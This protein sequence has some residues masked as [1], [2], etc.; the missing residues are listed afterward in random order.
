MIEDELRAAFA[1]HEALTPPAGPVRAAIDRVVAVRRRRRQRVRAAGVALALVGALGVGIPQLRPD[2]VVDDATHFGDRATPAPSGALNVLVLG[3]DLR[4]GDAPPLADSVLLVHVPADRS[5]PY[6]ISLP[7]DLEVDIPGHQRDKLNA[8]F[9]FGAGPGRPD[10]SRGYELTRRAVADLTGVRVDAGLVLTYPAL[11]KV[12]DSLG[13]VEVC[14]PQ[15]VTSA[16]TRRVYPAGCQRLDGTASVDLLRQRRGLPD[17]GLD[18][19]RNAQRFVAGLVRR[20]KEQ[21][22]VTDPVRLSRILSAVGPDL[23]VAGGSVPDL[24]RVIPQL[25]S[26]EPV[27]LSLPVVPPEGAKWQIRA[28]PGAAPAFLTA[29]REDRLA[30]WTTANPNRITPLR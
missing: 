17:G 1:R 4:S 26:V 11:R 10:L 8:A 16:H 14:L 22:V 24:L 3:L 25:A 13:G 19:D 28:D 9:A 18:R 30:E 6:L 20:A 2:P 7:R 12:T 15:K 5:R 29:L 27:G 23:T 21:D